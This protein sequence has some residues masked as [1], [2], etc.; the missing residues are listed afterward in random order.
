MAFCYFVRHQK[1]SVPMVRAP[2]KTTP[3]ESPSTVWTIFYLVTG[4]R[5]MNYDV[6][7][8]QLYPMRLKGISICFTMLKA[9]LSGNYVNFGVCK[10]YGDETL[11]NVLDVTT[12]LILTIPQSDLLV[13]VQ[14]NNPKHWWRVGTLCHIEY[15]FSGVSKIGTS[16][17]LVVG[18]FSSRSYGVPVDARSS[19]IFVH[20]KEYI[21]G[22]GCW[23]Y[24][25]F[26]FFRCHRWFIE[27]ALFP[28]T[29][30]IWA[31]LFSLFLSQ[32]LDLTIILYFVYASSFDSNSQ[33]LFFTL[34]TFFNY[35]F[36]QYEKRPERS[37]LN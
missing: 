5:I 18:M 3:F 23:R 16:I 13:S 9:A 28:F 12:K 37:F 30:L 32:N 14:S 8:N 4:N 7:K 36:I 27:R 20:Y 24:D 21:R 35:Y 11:D 33:L 22:F 15:H 17:F 29:I 26:N 25:E 6:P 10:L 2:N 19:N 1:S 31:Q 34:K